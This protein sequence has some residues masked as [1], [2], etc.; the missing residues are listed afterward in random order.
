MLLRSVEEWNAWREEDDATPDLREGDLSSAV[1][2]ED[3][4]HDE[5]SFISTATLGASRGR[6]PEAFLKGC[7]LSDLEIVM[8]RLWDPDLS[9]DELTTLLYRIHD[10][11]TTAPIQKRYVF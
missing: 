10:L 1:G 2:L 6:I 8:S 3:T 11:K 9:G 7:G 5:P 4:Q